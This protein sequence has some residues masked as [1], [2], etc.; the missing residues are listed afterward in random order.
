MT[1]KEALKRLA[2]EFGF[3]SVG[4]MLEAAILDSVC[5]GI[6]LT[7]GYTTEIEPDSQSGYCESCGGNAVR[8]AMVL[9]RVI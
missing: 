8:S 5:P 4:A 9:G 7:C 3:K 2:D 6:C 1:R